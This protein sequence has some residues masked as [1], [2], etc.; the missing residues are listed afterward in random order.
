M[1]GKRQE[2]EIL[3]KE[4]Y[5]DK[6]LIRE[7]EQTAAGNPLSYIIYEYCPRLDLFTYV[8]AR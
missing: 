3:L 1:L 8:A 5:R 7:H 4:T 6:K 2:N